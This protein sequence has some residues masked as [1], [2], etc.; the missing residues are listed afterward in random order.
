MKFIDA[1]VFVHA[2]LKH[3][4]SLTPSES[5]IKANAKKIVLRVN[6]GERVVTSAVHIAEIANLLEEY[7]PMEEAARIERTLCLR[8]NI[9]VAS[10]T[11]RDCVA[12]LE[13]TESRGIGL[14]DSLAYVIMKDRGIAELYSF[15]RDFDVISGL[16]RVSN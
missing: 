15:D 2:Y 12:A 11:R 6:E 16:K 1:S 7:I 5:A 8:E 14:S 13:E 3:S 9:D 10:V 4:R